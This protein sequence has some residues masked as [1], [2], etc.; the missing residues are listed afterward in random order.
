[1]L[2]ASSNLYKSAISTT[3]IDGAHTA[4]VNGVDYY[5]ETLV[6]REIKYVVNLYLKGLFLAGVSTEPVDNW[7]AYE[8]TNGITYYYD[9]SLGINDIIENVINSSIEIDAQSEEV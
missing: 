7:T 8:H 9:A 2:T 3:E 6:A 4:N 5:S 1:M